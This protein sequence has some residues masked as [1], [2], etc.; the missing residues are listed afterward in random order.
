M[1][2]WMGLLRRRCGYG[3]AAVWRGGSG[4]D[5]AIQPIEEP[6]RTFSRVTIPDAMPIDLQDGEYMFCGTGYE[7]F[8]GGVGF[9]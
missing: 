4:C 5:Q 3:E 2:R 8:F 6:L 1:R 9:L 7:C